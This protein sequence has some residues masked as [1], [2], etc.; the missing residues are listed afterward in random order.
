MRLSPVLLLLPVLA[1][2]GLTAIANDD[3]PVSPQPAIA[4]PAPA[5]LTIKSLAGTYRGV[6]DEKALKEAAKLRLDE[7][8]KRDI[9][10]EQFE[11]ILRRVYEEVKI[12]INVDGTFELSTDNTHESFLELEQRGKVKIDG[13]KLIFTVDALASTNGSANT[14]KSSDRCAF[15]LCTFTLYVAADR[16]TLLL[17]ESLNPADLLGRYVKQ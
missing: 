10:V 8:K 14:P 11:N 12:T 7:I 16:K 1:L 5:P 4:S 15:T 13:Y 9:T 17:N 3:H 2:S 6:V